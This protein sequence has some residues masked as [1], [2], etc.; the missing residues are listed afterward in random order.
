MFEYKLKQNKKGK[1]LAGLHYQ[2][3]KEKKGKKFNYYN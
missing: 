1:G 2:L 3:K